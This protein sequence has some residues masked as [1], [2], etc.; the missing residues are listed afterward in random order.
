MIARYVNVL[1]ERVAFVE[2]PS[3]AR[4]IE[5]MILCGMVTAS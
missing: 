4:A 3:V 5:H 1:F 2:F